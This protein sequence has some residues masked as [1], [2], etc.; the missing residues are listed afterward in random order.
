MINFCLINLILIYFKIYLNFIWFENFYGWAFNINLIRGFL[1]FLS[2]LIFFVIH[3]IRFELTIER[4]FL[5]DLIDLRLIILII[6]FLSD[7]IINFYLIIELSL[8][9]VFTIIIG[10]GYQPERLNAGIWIFLYTLL[11]A[12]PFFFEFFFYLKSFN[13]SNFFLFPY[14]FIRNLKS[15]NLIF[16]FLF[17]LGFLIKFPIYIIHIWLPRAHVEAPLIG[18]VLLAAILLKLAG[19]AIIK[20]NLFLIHIKFIRFIKLF[21]LGGGAYVRIICILEKDIKKLIAYRSVGHIRLVILRLFI[22]TNLGFKG[23]YLFILTHGVTSSVLFIGRYYIYIISQRR[24]IFLNFRFLNYWPIFTFFWFLR[25]LRGISAPPSRRFFSEILCVIRRLNWNLNFIPFIFI[26]LF[27]SVRYSIILYRMTQYGQSDPKK[28]FLLT[29][30]I[31]LNLI[32][33]RYIIFFFIFI[34]CF[35]YLESIIIVY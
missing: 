30:I 1:I 17:I 19:F 20:F 4:N 26:I 9:P 2:I 16:E 22:K 7:F 12:I 8:I 24:C 29:T 23:G 14:I 5:K 3:I 21:C 28:F 11:R 13:I 35:I 25:N 10:W 34:L 31:N 18:S 27:I 32:L 15:C 33:H 6:F